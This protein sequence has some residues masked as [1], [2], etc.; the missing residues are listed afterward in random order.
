MGIERLPYLSLSD[1]KPRSTIATVEKQHSP[2][3]GLSQPISLQILQRRSDP[4]GAARR[5]LFALLMAPK[6]APEDRRAAAFGAP[7][8]RRHARTIARSQIV[9]K[10]NLSVFLASVYTARPEIIQAT[11]AAIQGVYK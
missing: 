10:N 11:S 4:P 7:G 8:F 1:Q 9:G 5:G 2:H 6:E 3:V